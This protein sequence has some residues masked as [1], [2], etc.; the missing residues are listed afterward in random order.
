MRYPVPSS[1]PM[2]V[3]LFSYINVDVYLPALD[4]IF[5][6]CHTTMASRD[7]DYT[8]VP[9]INVKRCTSMFWITSNDEEISIEEL[10]SSE[11]LTTVARMVE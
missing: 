1:L 2:V 8:R 4:I 5:L 6:P 7:Y 9:S 3:S 11:L 10:H